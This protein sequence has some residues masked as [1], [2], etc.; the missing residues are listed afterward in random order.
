MPEHPSV[1]RPPIRR[2]CVRRNIA[3]TKLLFAGTPSRMARAHIRSLL[4]MEAHVATNVVVSKLDVDRVER[5][6]RAGKPRSQVFPRLSEL[7]SEVDGEGATVTVRFVKKGGAP[8]RY[9]ADEL[10]ELR[11]L[12]RVASRPDRG[13]RP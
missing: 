13:L 1:L 12:C 5:G 7:T 10:A 11:G 9:V 8:V 2:T 3:P 6:I 4:A